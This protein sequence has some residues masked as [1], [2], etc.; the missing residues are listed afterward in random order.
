[1]LGPDDL[2]LCA[3]TLGSAPLREKIEAAADAGFRG[4]SLYPADLQQARAAG[5]SYKEL[6]H[7]LDDRGLE[8]AELDPL[9]SWIPN[10]GLGAEA[11]DE[12]RA[13]FQATERDFYAVAE[14]IGGRSI[15]AVLIADR[16]VPNAEV[17][18][19]FAGL[20]DRAAEHGLVVHL[21]FL[22]WTQIRDARGALE[23]AE[24]AGRPNGGV[25]FDTW[26]HF[27]S[28]E[29]DAVLREIP[30]ERLLGI[31]L[32]D[33]PREADANLVSETLQRR[34]LPGEGDIDLI[35]ILRLLRASGTLA[36]LGVEVFSNEL[37]AL[38][39]GEAAR[40]VMAAT[41]SV[42]AAA[43]GSG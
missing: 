40:R 26:H 25:M 42:V 27:R 5:L 39:P 28:G 1:M 14:A 17:A 9:M 34:R 10:T 2:V 33:A 31:Q 36:P 35:E 41:R 30:G 16:P 38:P 32:N 15:N 43:F 20:C 18:E 23:I 12:G 19:A 3:G 13:L 37:N 29:P 22:P 21:E 6:R 11:T 24:L 4:V 7:L 8:V